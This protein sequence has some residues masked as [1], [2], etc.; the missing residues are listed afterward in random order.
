MGFVYLIQLALMSE[1]VDAQLCIPLLPG[2]VLC[3]KC[4]DGLPLCLVIEGGLLYICIG[5]VLSYADELVDPWQ[6]VG[7]G[8]GVGGVGL[9]GCKS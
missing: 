2:R 9:I 6:V 1:T 8:C 7:W 5:R 3:L 4:V